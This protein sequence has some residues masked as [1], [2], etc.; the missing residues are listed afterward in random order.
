[1]VKSYKNV[2]ILWASVKGPYNYIQ[3][4]QI[5]CNIITV[6]PNIIEKI[7]SFVKSYKQLTYET[8]FGFLKDCRKSNFKIC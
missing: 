5:G 8:V 4:R 2:K 3:A 1:M 7:E 6:P